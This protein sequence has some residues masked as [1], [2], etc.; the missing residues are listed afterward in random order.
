VVTPG[1]LL[2][3]DPFEDTASI[4]TCSLDTVKSSNFLLLRGR[5]VFRPPT[6]GEWGREMEK[7]EESIVL[8]SYRMAEPKQ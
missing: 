1:I 6:R 4:I 7:I 8:H 3:F 5:S 2:S